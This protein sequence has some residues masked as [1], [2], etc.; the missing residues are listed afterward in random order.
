MKKP[1]NDLSVK[2]DY[3]IKEVKDLKRESHKTFLLNKTTYTVKE[4]ALVSSLS[5]SHIY[6]SIHLGELS[7][8]RPSYK[9]ILIK[10]CDLRRFL[11]SNHIKE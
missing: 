2:I 6:Q 3:L 5:E 10:R 4:A 7:H 11:K 1:I 8:N 9:R